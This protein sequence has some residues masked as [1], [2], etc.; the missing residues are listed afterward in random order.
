MFYKVKLRN[1]H[2]CVYDVCMCE[3][4]KAHVYVCVCVCVVSNH[5]HLLRKIKQSSK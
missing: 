5:K 3:R 1:L 2:K 4:K